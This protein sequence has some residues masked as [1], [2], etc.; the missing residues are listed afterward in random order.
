MMLNID[1][2]NPLPEKISIEGI[3]NCYI[4]PDGSSFYVNIVDEKIKN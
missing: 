3:D 1:D 4:M 2:Y